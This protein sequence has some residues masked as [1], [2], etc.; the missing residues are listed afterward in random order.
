MS[1]D[2]LSFVGAVAASSPLPIRPVVYCVF[3]AIII[4][5][6]RKWINGRQFN[7]KLDVSGK[8]AIVTGSNTGIGKE[9][10]LGLAR[11]GVHVILACR[12]MQAAAEARNDIISATG[13]RNVRCMKLDL[14]S[15]KSIRT[16]ADEFLATGSPLHI[17]INNAGVMGMD[18]RTTEDGLEEHIGVNHFGHFLLTLLLLRRLLESK[19]SR[20]VNVSSWGHN[21]VTMHKDDLMGE[22]NYN[23][24]HAYGQSKLANIYFTRSLAKRLID[25]GVNSNALHPGVIFTDLSRNLESFSWIL[26]KY[27]RWQ[28]DMCRRFD[29]FI[30]LLRKLPLSFLGGFATSFRRFFCGRRKPGRRQVYPLHWIRTFKKLMDFISRECWFI[31]FLTSSS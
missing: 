30:F 7:M 28:T 9:T 25:T 13:N 8:V 24:F 23:R 21:L 5:L 11:Y 17:L 14:A 31:I 29:Y 3:F 22:K 16:F 10:A 27:V 4:Y 20:V 1:T 26:Q 18:R 15:F 19:P 12:N 6:Y 2:S